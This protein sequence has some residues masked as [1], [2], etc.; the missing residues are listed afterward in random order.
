VQ[1]GA[2]NAGDAPCYVGIQTVDAGENLVD[3]QRARAQN[4][5][6][7]C[8]RD[9]AH[10]R[11]PQG[12]EEFRVAPEFGQAANLRV[13][14]VTVGEFAGARNVIIDGAFESHSGVFAHWAVQ[15][16]G[17]I[18]SR[19]TGEKLFGGG[20][21][22]ITGDGVTSGEITQDLAARDPAIPSGR[23]FGFGAWVRASG[24]T[25]GN[26][27]ID[28]LVN[29]APSGLALVIDDSTPDAQWLHKG[30]IEYLPRASFPNKVVVRIR[31]SADFDGVVNIDGVSL[32]PAA[33]VPH[34]GLRVAIFQGTQ[35]PQASPIADRYTVATASD[36]AGAFQTFMRDK[37]GN[38]LPTDD[39]A[40]I[41]DDLAK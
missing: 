32:A 10:H 36:D 35:G 41:D 1:A 20:S 26:V 28:L 9:A 23:F 34:A 14:P 15:S 21:L 24:I 16:G 39:L 12:Q 30:G 18:F 8:T 4:V 25:A 40:S 27:T 7:E 31:A 5:L 11:V 22:K 38:A 17:A 13:I 19:D 2:A 33:D 29:G 37:L 3:D 6:V